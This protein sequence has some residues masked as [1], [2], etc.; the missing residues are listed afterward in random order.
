[1][2][3][4]DYFKIIHKY[5]KPGSL[6]Y[7][8]YIPHV[9]L[10]TAKSIRIGKKLGLPNN[11]LRFIEEAAMLHDIGIIRVNDEELGCKGKLNYLCHGTEGRKILENEKLVKHAKVAE[12]HTGVGIFKDEIENNELPLPRKDILA[13]TLEEKI[14]SYA[15]LFFSKNPQMIWHEKSVKEARRSIEEFGERHIKL[16]NEWFKKFEC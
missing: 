3:K 8:L 13:I 7:S 2:K 6:T 9:S 15:D 1:M 12:N 14:I 10:I 16:F 11:N 4:V 5:I